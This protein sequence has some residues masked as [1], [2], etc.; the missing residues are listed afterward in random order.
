M[1]RPRPGVALLVLLA[2]ISPAAAVE[3]GDQALQEEMEKLRQE[4]QKNHDVLKELEASRERIEKVSSLSKRAFE[5]LRAEKYDEAEKAL[6]EW[7]AVDPE[8]SRLPLLKELVSRLKVESNPARAAD[9]WAD[10][11]NKS[12]KDLQ[13][14]KENFVHRDS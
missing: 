5:L 13:P 2:A 8:N 1:N 6:L 11:F 14:K 9:L 4:V 7:E 12:L 10:Y 3:Q